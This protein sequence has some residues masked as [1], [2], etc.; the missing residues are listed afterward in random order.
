MPEKYSISVI[1]PVFNGEKF[2]EKCILNVISQNDPEVEH[3]IVDGGST[4][5]TVEIIKKIS[6]KYPHLSWI[7]EKDKGQSDAMNRGI[8][9]ARGSIISFLNVD[10]YYEPGTLL[11][12]EK[13]FVTLAEPSLLVGN[14]NIWD[15]NNRLLAVNKPSHLKLQDLLIGTEIFMHPVNPS[16]YFYHKSL[17][18]RIGLYDITDNNSM[19]LD[20]ILR[21][22]QV[23][24]VK[25]VNELFGNYRYIPGTKTFE[26]QKSLGDS[27]A[28][29]LHKK[30]ETQLSRNDKYFLFLRRKFHYLK[31][32]AKQLV[33]PIYHRFLRFW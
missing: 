13:L 29:N 8:T 25:Y 24:N 17:H 14:C 33:R 22:V 27:R 10:D 4:D 31:Y 15:E 21:A 9:L 7:S 2:I 28:Y 20:F 16:A 1:T 5:R 23:A 18:E 3:L 26:D 6:D 11:R 19:D 30:Y 32:F 12:V